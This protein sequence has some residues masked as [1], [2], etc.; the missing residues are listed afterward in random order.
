MRINVKFNGETYLAEMSEE[1]FNYA[2]NYYPN[3]TIS[4]KGVGN[5]EL[6]VQIK[7]LTMESINPEGL[8]AY[9]RKGFT[10]RDTE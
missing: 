7:N 10:K 9:T 2:K 4:I 5:T 6:N 1:D 3:T 8:S